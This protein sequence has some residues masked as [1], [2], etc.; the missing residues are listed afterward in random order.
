MKIYFYKYNSIIKN[1]S[2]YKR[3]WQEQIY[4]GIIK[5]GK[6]ISITDNILDASFII[7]IL[8]YIDEIERNYELK[9]LNIKLIIISCQDPVTIIKN[10]I[11][12]PNV[13]Y[14][15]DH[16]KLINV[17]NY[18]INY[19]NSYS[20]SKYLLNEYYKLKNEYIF[21]DEDIEFKKLYENKTKCILNT[22][23]IYRRIF[24]NSPLSIKQ[25]KYDVVNIGNLNLD[26][27]LS[28]HRKDIVKK[29]QIIS[30]KYNLNVYLG[31]N[32]DGNKLPLHKYYRLL[33]KTKIVVSPW[34]WGEWSLKEFECICFG[35]HCII[36][37]KHLTNY[38]NY[39][40]NFDEYSVN[41]SDL[42]EK[43]MYAL[44][45][46]DKTQLKID[47]NRKLFLE[48]NNEKQINYI[49]ELLHS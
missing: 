15:F 31:D 36:P 40:E 21:V 19:N 18:Y 34:G 4:N 35:V 44:N 16:L 7:T 12:N 39:Y 10:I 43:I 48:Y 22:S 6:N 23:Y 37:N 46:L 27:L 32:N 14:I 49:E 2:Q 41:F 25:R 1:L 38:P 47:S 33:K 29:L 28:P 3:F 26:G 5:Y 42:E 24:D 17:P 8:D 20:Y 11:M 45:N 9:S 13:L 30:Q